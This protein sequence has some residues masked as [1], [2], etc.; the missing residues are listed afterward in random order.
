MKKIIEIQKEI[1]IGNVVLEK[2]D[3]I[4]VLKEKKDMLVFILNAIKREFGSHDLDPSM[5]GEAIGIT[6]AEV[7][8]HMFSYDEDGFFTDGVISGLSEY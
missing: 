1:K 7:R 8:D 5:V 4:Q 6:L 2:G 3:R